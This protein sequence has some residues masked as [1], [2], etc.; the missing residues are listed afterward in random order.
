[1]HYCRGN[2]VGFTGR[3][4]RCARRWPAGIIAHAMPSVL[5]SISFGPRRPAPARPVDRPGPHDQPRRVVVVVPRAP[6]AVSPSVDTRDDVR[7]V[8]ARVLAGCQGRSC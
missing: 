7:L 5:R 8:F 3:S 4:G 2:R 1:M 6:V